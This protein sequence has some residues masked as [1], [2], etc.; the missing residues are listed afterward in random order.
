MSVIEIVAG[1]LLIVLFQIIEK[2]CIAVRG[3]RGC[4][5]QFHWITCF[6]KS[7]FYKYKQK[8]KSYTKICKKLLDK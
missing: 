7:L 6:L 3:L 1:A 4:L 8:W 5:K 2:Y